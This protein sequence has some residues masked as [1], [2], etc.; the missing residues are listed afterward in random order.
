MRDQG[1]G[2]HCEHKVM[3]L[4]LQQHDWLVVEGKVCPT[5]VARV[6]GEVSAQRAHA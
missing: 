6:L 4:L 2:T 1:G 5:L 3:E